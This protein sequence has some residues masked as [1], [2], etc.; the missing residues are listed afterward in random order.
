MKLEALALTS[1]VVVASAAA[2]SSSGDGN[3]ANSGAGGAAG[4]SGATSQSVKIA[5]WWKAP[6]EAEAIDGL[7]KTFKAQNTGYSV[8]FDLIVDGVTAQSQLNAELADPVSKPPP[9]VA[10]YN[11]N[12]VPT[13]LRSLPDSLTV[14]DGAFAASS[15]TNANVPQEVLDAVTVDGHIYSIPLNI[16]RENSFFYNVAVLS[17]NGITPPT[18][19]DEIIAA[20]PKLKAAKI[21]PVVTSY[22]GWIQ[23][24]M[25]NSIAAGTMGAAK[26]RDFMT[27]K[28]SFTDAA[29]SG[30]IDKYAA[31]LDACVDATIA[32]DKEYGWTRAADDLF[33][34]KGAFYYHGDW[35]KGYL[36]SR[37]FSP[38]TDFG[39]GGSPGARDLFWFGVDVL[40]LP[41]NAAN[42]AGAALFFDTATSIDGQVAFNKPKGSTPFRTD[43]PAT[44]LD[45]VGQLTHADFKA[46][47]EIRMLVYTTN[48]L[49]TALGEFATNRDKAALLKAYTDNPIATQ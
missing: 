23:R 42:P 8:T 37:G 2:C 20:C 48:A 46:A 10:Q 1:I 30:A 5:S 4:H 21:T 41:K 24:I 39:G 35:A 22:Q 13:L 14:L 32:S 28:T 25:F 26:F 27:G 19:V 11:A 36:V 29:W 6:G 12:N 40:I 49:D 38:G 3:G 34:G 45:A 43:V 9:D 16:H 31:L 17:A 47:G 18:T 33:E 15:L 44:S 7:I